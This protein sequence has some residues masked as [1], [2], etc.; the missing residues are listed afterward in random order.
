MVDS[1]TRAAAAARSGSGSGKYKA[2]ALAASARN[3]PVRIGLFFD[4][5]MTEMISDRRIK[6]WRFDLSR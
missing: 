3:I 5:W 2:L 4:H 1:H 6:I